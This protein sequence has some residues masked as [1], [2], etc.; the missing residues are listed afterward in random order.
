MPKP[1]V[2]ESIWL[3]ELDHFA[4]HHPSFMF[5]GR[6]KYTTWYGTAASLVMFALVLWY[7]LPKILHTFSTHNPASFTI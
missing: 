7:M 6:P 5:K 2:N 4:Q 1:R 3:K